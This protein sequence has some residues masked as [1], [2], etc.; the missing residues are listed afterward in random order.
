MC[1]VIFRRLNDKALHTSLLLMFCSVGGF[2]P[3]GNGVLFCDSHWATQLSTEPQAKP[4]GL[5]WGF[6]PAR[7]RVSFLLPFCAFQ[8]SFSPTTPMSSHGRVLSLLM[9]MLLSCCG[10]AVICC[11]TGY[12]H[13]MHTLAFMAVEVRCRQAFA[14]SPFLRIF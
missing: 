1:G 6:S 14:R 3:T 12:I 5:T 2:G 4:P 10:L 7:G 13:G 11:V 9:A 8:L